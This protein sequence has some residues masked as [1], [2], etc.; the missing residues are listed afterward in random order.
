MRRLAAVFVGVVSFMS[1]G[2]ALG[3]PRQ[4]VLVDFCPGQD[5]GY[6]IA[7]R[8]WTFACNSAGNPFAATPDPVARGFRWSHWGSHQA[9]GTGRVV[10]TSRTGTRRTAFVRIWL[11][12]P[13]SCGTG[14]M[15]VY[16]KFKIR[17]LRGSWYE[18][19]RAS[20]GCIPTC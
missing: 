11:S 12:R 19:P 8:T 18:R 10:T 16:M 3:F 4:D 15:W 2:T 14:G 6:H 1:A 13:Q 7:P 9:V 17:L 20:P 5:A